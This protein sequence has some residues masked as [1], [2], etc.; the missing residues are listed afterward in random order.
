MI[1]FDVDQRMHSSPTEN[2]Q[3]EELRMGGFRKGGPIFISLF[4]LQPHLPQVYSIPK[5]TSIVKP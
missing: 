1:L 2:G 4:N 5:T 3:D